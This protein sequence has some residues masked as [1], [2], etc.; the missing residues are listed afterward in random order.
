[1]Q[2]AWPALS[3]DLLV[4]MLLKHAFYVL[5]DVWQALSWFPSNEPMRQDT[6]YIIVVEMT[7]KEVAPVASDSRSDRPYR[8]ATLDTQR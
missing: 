8:R 6:G 7:A 4:D 2:S 3:C 1:M 5:S